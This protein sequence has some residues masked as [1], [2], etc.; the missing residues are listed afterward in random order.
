MAGVGEV[1]EVDD[2][3]ENADD[4]DNLGKKVSKVIN[5]L[6]EGSLLANLGRD[7]RVDVADGR[8]GSGGR[9]DGA[10]GTINNGRS[11]QTNVSSSGLKP[12]NQKRQGGVIIQ[13]RAC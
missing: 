12:R 1:A 3:D 7:G 2:P 9:D 13:R 8:R 11:L 6:L 10:R 4:G 5:L